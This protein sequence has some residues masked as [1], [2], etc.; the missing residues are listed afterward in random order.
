MR[1]SARA[2]A[3]N[4]MLHRRPGGADRLTTHILRT[5]LAVPVAALAGAVAAHVLAGQF[6]AAAFVA[7]YLMWML[8]EARIPVGAP[9]Q[10]SAENRTLIPY[11]LARTT[12]ALVAAYSEPAVSVAISVVLVAV[13]LAG[14]TLR[15]WAIDELGAQ[16]SHR[17]VKVSE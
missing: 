12:T 5:P 3:G 11:A 4:D 17:V 8:S 10:S 15:A 2:R 6:I 13:F 7:A 1:D 16:Y 14:V 9:S